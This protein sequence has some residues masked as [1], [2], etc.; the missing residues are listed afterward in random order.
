MTDEQRKR[1]NECAR[2]NS[3]WKKNAIYVFV[4][5]NKTHIHL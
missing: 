2:E 1:K 5:V 4:V 3:R